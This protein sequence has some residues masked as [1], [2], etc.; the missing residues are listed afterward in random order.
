M[1]PKVMSSMMGF[2]EKPV[3]IQPMPKTI[4]LTSMIL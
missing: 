2:V 1:M 3:R 4:P